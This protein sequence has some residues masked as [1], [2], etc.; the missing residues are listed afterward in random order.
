MCI[1]CL[2]FTL[3]VYSRANKMIMLW[4]QLH[5]L[6]RKYL[7][8]VLSLL[9]FF[10]PTPL[11]PFC[12]L[13]TVLPWVEKAEVL[14]SSFFFFLSRSLALFHG[15]QMLLALSFSSST[16]AWTGE[17]PTRILYSVYSRL[18]IRALPC[19]VVTKKKKKK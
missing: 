3:Y 7:L 17:I 4:H 9:S 1:C 18:C 12:F 14:L 8:V 19:P 15:A 13:Y 10:L 6:T 5:P 2:F 16:F 11:K